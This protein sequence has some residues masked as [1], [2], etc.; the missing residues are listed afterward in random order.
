MVTHD[1]EYHKTHLVPICDSRDKYPKI[2]L[3][4]FILQIENKSMIIFQLFF[5]TTG[6][7][8]LWLK[9]NIWH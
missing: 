2:F 4:L 9:I 5:L 7:L 6:V 3:D 8:F 1:L